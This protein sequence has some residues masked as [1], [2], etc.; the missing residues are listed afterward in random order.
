[1]GRL[2]QAL[3]ALSRNAPVRAVARSSGIDVRA[4]R[5]VQHT[6]PPDALALLER[7]DKTMRT[8]SGWETQVRAAAV[9]PAV[10]LSSV[11]VCGA[12]FA[13]L[14]VPALGALPSGRPP[15]LWP[16][17]L[18]LAFTA[19]SLLA[20]AATALRG[21]RVPGLEAW[22]VVDEAT[23]T[24][25]AADAVESGVALPVALRAAGRPSLARSLEAGALQPPAQATLEF[26]FLVSAAVTG[27]E[28]TTAGSLRALVDARLTR[29]IPRLTAR[30]HHVAVLLAGLSLL[31]CAAT[32]FSIYA[33]RFS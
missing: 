6:S 18:A 13:F 20:V 11:L 15:A 4:L 27:V 9:W 5:F 16:S 14:T 22:R 12:V 25:L 33:S 30:R 2:T 3:D 29:V 28:K 26:R 7:S 19:A 24:L 32:F 23:A 8:I 17:Y 10:L 1:M 21:V 31:A